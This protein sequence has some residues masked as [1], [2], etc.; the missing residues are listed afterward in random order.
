MLQ[1]DKELADLR[2]AEAGGDEVRLGDLWAE[3]TV[4]VAWL[5]HYR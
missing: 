3:Q 1:I 5:R 2:L 4:V